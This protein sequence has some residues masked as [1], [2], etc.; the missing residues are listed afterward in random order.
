MSVVLR[1]D[2]MFGPNPVKITGEFIVGNMGGGFGQVNEQEDDESIDLDI[3]DAETVDTTPAA[4][5]NKTI[6]VVPG[7]FKPPH[8]GHLAMIEQYAADNEEVKVLISNPLK[9][10]RTLADGTVITAAHAKRMWDSLAA[11]L[12]NVDIEVSSLA[13]PMNA[14]YEYIGKDG[15]LSPGDVV[16]LGSSLKCDDWK[17]WVGAEK[18]VKDGVEF[19]DPRMGACAPAPHGPEY[20]AL[21]EH[22]PL[23][24]S[25]PSITDSKKDPRDFHA[26]DMRYLLGMATTDAEAVELLEDFVGGDDKVMDF[27]SILGI[28][29]GL[30]EPLEETSSMGG[31]AVSGPT[32]VKPGKRDKADPL[33]GRSPYTGGKRKKKKTKTENIDMSLVNEVYGLLIERGIKL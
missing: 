8:R 20:M 31:G 21:L 5:A 30:N 15:P 9:K 33:V 3:I 7:A 28:D 23:K 6:A 4:A 29:T 2:K 25:M 16:T 32:G 18:Y 24:E 22:S 13:S 11:H 19:K 14:A 26:S 27:L 17:R 10:Q 12:A 1:H